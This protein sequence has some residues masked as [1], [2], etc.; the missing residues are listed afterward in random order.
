[1]EATLHMLDDTL[2]P[3][4]DWVL[5]LLE[6]SQSLQEA[7]LHLVQAGISTAGI[8]TANLCLQ[9][10]YQPSAFLTQGKLQMLTH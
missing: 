4:A 10:S 1:M 3:L 7:G 6:D 5:E 2:L 9:T 8:F